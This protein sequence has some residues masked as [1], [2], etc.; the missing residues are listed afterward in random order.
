MKQIAIGLLTP[1]LFVQ[2]GNA[3]DSPLHPKTFHAVVTYGSADPAKTTVLKGYLVNIEDSALYLSVQPVPVCFDRTDLT[4]LQKFDLPNLQEIKIHQKGAFG[5]S[6]LIGLVSGLAVGLVLASWINQVPEPGQV[7][8]PPPSTQLGNL[9]VG[10]F[11]GAT[12]GAGTGAVCGAVG[13]KKF[14]IRGEWKN[15]AAVKAYMLHQ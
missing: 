1:L 11:L 10:G 9:L 13:G 3:Q 8:P 12:L 6:V 7:G 2:T 4:N 14:L 5:K 15:L